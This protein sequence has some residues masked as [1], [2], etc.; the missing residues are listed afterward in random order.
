MDV[1]L[2]CYKWMDGWMYG[3]PGGKKHF[4]VLI[5][6]AFKLFNFQNTQSSNFFRR[7]RSSENFWYS[8][9]LQ[10]STDFE[11]LGHIPWLYPLHQPPPHLRTRGLTWS[12][13][14]FGEE[15]GY[16]GS[17]AI[18][19]IHGAGLPGR[20]SSLPGWVAVDGRIHRDNT[21][22][23]WLRLILWN[24][25]LLPTLSCSRQTTSHNLKNRKEE[26]KQIFS[27]VAWK[28]VTKR[29]VGQW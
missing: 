10:I 25:S 4:W 5:N 11:D 3:S 9:I 8:D 18:F 14:L 12:R 6:L 13:Q 21:A 24:N 20:P 2:W 22:P 29:F 1:A 26:N 27:S 7:G 19:R 16:S 17:R 28:K 23:F 15:F